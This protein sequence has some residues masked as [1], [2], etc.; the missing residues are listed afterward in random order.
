MYYLFV[1]CQVWQRMSNV[2]NMYLQNWKCHIYGSSCCKTSRECNNDWNN[3]MQ[4]QISGVL[5]EKRKQKIN[6]T[7]GKTYKSVLVSKLKLFKS[8][9]QS[10]CTHTT[11]S[12]SYKLCYWELM[13]LRSN[14]HVLHSELKKWQPNHASIY[15]WPGLVLGRK[16][17]IVV[18]CVKL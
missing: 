14:H 16:S 11:C 17:D 9:A 15:P 4:W 5:Y 12:S 13:L 8:Q 3:P 18:I 10:S 1:C 6:T 2:L 7:S